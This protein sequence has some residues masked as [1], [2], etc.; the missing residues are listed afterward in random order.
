MTE[1]KNWG[2][3]N[4]ADDAAT[5]TLGREIK[6][7]EEARDNPP[8]EAL[9]GYQGRLYRLLFAGLTR[10]GRRAHLQFRDRTGRSFWADARDVS[11]IPASPRE[12][13]IAAPF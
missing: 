3:T 7:E 12:R 1:V 5:A 9:A 2:L 13:A 4:V 10:Y 8:R 11:G 6:E